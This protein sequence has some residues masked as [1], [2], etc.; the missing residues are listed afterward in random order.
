M[1]RDVLLHG[2][3]LEGTGTQMDKPFPGI[4]RPDSRGSLTLRSAD[5]TAPPVIDPRHLSE[6]AD[7]QGLVR[8][9]EVCREIGATRAFKPWTTG[10]VA[11]A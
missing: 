5:T 8:G 1:P 3:L 11:A 9:I 4:V 2:A 7:V 6:E 10:E